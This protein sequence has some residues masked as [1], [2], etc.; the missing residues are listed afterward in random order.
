MYQLI[1]KGIVYVQ[2]YNPRSSNKRKDVYSKKGLKQMWSTKTNSIGDIFA[3]GN[4]CVGWSM[5]WFNLK[6]ITIKT[7]STV[8][9][10]NTDMHTF[11]KKA[12]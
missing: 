10:L 11:V 8:L 7:N 2:L 4:Q 6:K 3:A 9:Q 12:Y 1:E 5:W